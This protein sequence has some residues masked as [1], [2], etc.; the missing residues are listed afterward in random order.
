[1]CTQRSGA[2][3][4]SIKRLVHHRQDIGVLAYA[5][6][7]VAAPNGDIQLHFS[8]ERFEPGDMVH[9]YSQFC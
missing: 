4:R 8:D 7:V 1:M 2:S 3:T 6:I 5:E 9:S